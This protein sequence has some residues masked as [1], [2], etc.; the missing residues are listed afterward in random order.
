[1][2]KLKK[3]ELKKLEKI[4]SKYEGENGSLVSVLQEI[5]RELGYIPQQGFRLISEKTAVPQSQIYGVITFY[6]QF[7]LE[8]HGKYTIKI[9][10]GTACYL[11]GAKDITDSLSDELGIKV[12]ET[13]DDRLFT[14]ETV[15][16]LGACGL[17]PVMMINDETFGR[18]TPRQA[19]RVI[20]VTKNKKQE[21][22]NGR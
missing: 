8:P 16:C 2:E 21:D 12:G 15:S 14:I 22:K 7:R 11:C 4:I 10:H 18:L 19:K 20:R 1:M 3:A 17:A 9:C 13:T 6:D 5:Q